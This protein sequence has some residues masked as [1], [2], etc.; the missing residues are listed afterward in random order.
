MYCKANRMTHLL[1]RYVRDNSS[2]IKW[3]TTSIVTF[4]LNNPKNIK[5]SKNKTMGYF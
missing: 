3:T 5:L 4:N 1:A 2:P